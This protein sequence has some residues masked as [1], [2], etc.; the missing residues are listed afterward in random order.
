MK[1]LLALLLTCAMVLSLGLL[2]GCGQTDTGDANGDSQ[3]AAET[4]GQNTDTNTGDLEK[5]VFTEDVRGYHWAPAYL[6][7]TLG[8]F[9]EE[10][11][12]AEFQTIKGGDATAPVLS[13]DAQF[14]L[15]GV[16]TS[17]MVNEGGQGMKIL[18]STTQKY[19][20]QLI[21]ATS[22][23]STLE[24]LKGGVVA[25]GLSVN[26]GPYTFARACMADAGFT[27]EDVTITQMA[28]AGYA[29]AIQDGELQGAVSTNPWS[30]KKLTDAGGV[31]IIDGTDSY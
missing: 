16:E 8:Y 24:S 13:G 22:Q 27:D 6:A 29:A 7:Q 14:C 18:L 15:K 9:K 10:G 28:S 5:I 11:L 30:A 2:A 23:Y 25:G 12:D 1:K 3:S 31:V 17:L 26:S 19:P 21:G 20:Y 4:D